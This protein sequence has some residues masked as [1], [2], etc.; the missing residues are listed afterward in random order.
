[1]D[2]QQHIRELLEERGW[3]EYKQRNGKSA[4]ST[5]S[6]LFKRNNVPTLYTLEA[7]CKAFGMTLAQFFSE[8][9]EPMELTEEQRALFAKWATLSEKQKRVLFELIDIM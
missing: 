6:N 9:K 4:Q 2:V 8:G 3:S 1:M 5:I 7:I